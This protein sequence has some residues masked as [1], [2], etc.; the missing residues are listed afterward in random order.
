[1]INTISLFLE[2]A[3]F[4][5]PKHTNKDG[6]FLVVYNILTI[7]QIYNESDIIFLLYMDLFVEFSAIQR[8]RL[9]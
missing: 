8:N 7:V 1:M 4:L 6:V 2:R 5:Y 9:I 3:L